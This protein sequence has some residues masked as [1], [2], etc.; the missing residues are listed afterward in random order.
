MRA[1]GPEIFGILNITADS[2]SDGGKFL[3]PEN[4]LAQ[5]QKLVDAG[6]HV[7]DIGP[8]SS[9]PDASDV[10]PADEMQRLA[11]VWS[12]L[13]RVGAAL[14]VDSFR[15]ETQRWAMAHEADWLNDIHGFQDVAL[16]DE[17]A[18]AKCRLVVMHAVQSK[19]IATRQAPPGGDIWDHILRF[20]ETRLRVLEAAGIAR[21]RLVVDPGMGFFLGNDPQTSLQVLGGLA[22][23]KDEFDLPVLV[24]VSRKSF[25]RA[26]A[27]CSVEAS[28]PISLAAELLACEQGVDYLRTHDVLPLAQALKLRAAAKK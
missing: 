22:R 5:A 8:A 11:S 20:F 24:C 1:S 28:G 23:L 12:Q 26:V 25:L 17:L 18:D 10:S 19:G 3:A 9:H 13:K 4:A 6:A 7:L 2:F 21:E 14:S 15:S 16:H 27:D